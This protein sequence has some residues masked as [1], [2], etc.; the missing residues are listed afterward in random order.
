MGKSTENNAGCNFLN[1]RD[2]YE[3][4]KLDETIQY[5]SVFSI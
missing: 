5:D 4:V 2:I 1:I 3:H